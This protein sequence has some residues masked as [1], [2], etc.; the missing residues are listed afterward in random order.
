MLK[1]LVVLLL[2]TIC[3]TIIITLTHIYN[4]FHWSVFLWCTARPAQARTCFKLL[5]LIFRYD[6]RQANITL[7]PSFI[8]RILSSIIITRLILELFINYFKTLNLLICDFFFDTEIKLFLNK[9]LC[10]LLNQTEV[11]LWFFLHFFA[12]W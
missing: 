3:G 9:P 10:F 7:W 6:H 5:M 11:S 4:K 2:S 12:F 8:A 1:L